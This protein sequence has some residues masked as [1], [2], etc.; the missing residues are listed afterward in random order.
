LQ[1]V[2]KW[3]KRFFVGCEVICCGLRPWN[4]FRVTLSTWTDYCI[5]NEAASKTVTPWS[6][7]SDP[8]ASQIRLIVVLPLM[9]NLNYHIGF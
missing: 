8:Q 1:V 5:C 7:R 4:K 2:A 3:D 9:K 6:A